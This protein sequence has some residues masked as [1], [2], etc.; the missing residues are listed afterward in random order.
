MDERT[1]R[2]PEHEGG[3]VHEDHYETESLFDEFGRPRSIHVS[4]HPSR[5]RRAPVEAP[6][7]TGYD[8]ARDR[9]RELSA[10]HRALAASAMCDELLADFGR[11]RVAGASRSRRRRDSAIGDQREHHARMRKALTVVG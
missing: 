2:G 7:E 5:G 10:E 11:R 8:Q 9:I 4:H 3:P 6:S 1:T